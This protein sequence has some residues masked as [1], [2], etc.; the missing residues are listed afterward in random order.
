MDGKLLIYE[1]LSGGLFIFC[2]SVNP[3]HYLPPQVLLVLMVWLG[4]VGLVREGLRDQLERQVTPV[5]RVRQ[6]SRATVRQRCVWLHQR[7]PPRDYRRPE[8]SKD[9]V[10]KSSV[11]LSEVHHNYERGREREREK[12]REKERHHSSQ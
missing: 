7:T 10:F 5:R 1:D 3:L 12:E 6:V 2:S 4:K 11:S 8:R 9:P